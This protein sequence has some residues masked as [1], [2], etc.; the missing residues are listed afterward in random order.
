M[1]LTKYIDKKIVVSTVVGA[2]AVG[3]ISYFAIK[4]NVPVVKDIA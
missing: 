4:Y 2:L 1:K 3:A